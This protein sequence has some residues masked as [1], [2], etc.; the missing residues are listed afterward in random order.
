MSLLVL[1]GCPGYRQHQPNAIPSANAG[2]D[3]SVEGGAQVTLRGEGEDLDDGPGALS[4]RWEQLAGDMAALSGTSDREVT[5]LAPERSQAMV[6]S[7]RV[8]DGIEESQPDLVQVTVRFNRRPLA[9]AGGRREVANLSPLRLDGAA[10]DPDGDAIE[11]W[12]WTVESGPAGSNLASRLVGER[13]RYAV[14]TPDKKGEYSVSLV[15]GDGKAKS[16]KAHV[17][18]TSVN[19]PP[20][21]DVGAEP[22]RSIANRQ[23][24][25]VSGTASDPDGDAVASYQWDVSEIPPGGSFALANDQAKDATFTPQTKGTWVLSFHASDGDRESAPAKLLVISSNNTPQVAVPAQLSTPNGAA[26]SVAATGSDLD[27]DLLTYQWKVT[28]AAGAYNLSGAASAEATLIPQQ[29]GTYVLQVT[30]TD[31]APQSTAAVAIAQV[32]ATNRPPTAAVTSV[33]AVSAGDTVT[34]DA[35]SSSDPDGDS[36]SYELVYV[37]GPAVPGVPLQASPLL[38]FTAPAQKGMVQFQLLVTDSDGAKSGALPVQVSISNLPPV[39]E[40]GKPVLY[41]E[42]GTAV[43]LSASQS[44]DPENDPISAW[45]WAQPQGQSV[46]LSSGSTGSPSFTAPAYDPMAPP[47]LTFYLEVFDGRVWSTNQDEVEVRIT[48]DDNSYVFLSPGATGLGTRAQPMSDVVQAL[49]RASTEGKDVVFAGGTYPAASASAISLKNGVSLFGGFKPPAAGADDAW[50]RNLGAFQSVIEG[51]NGTASGLVSVL[52]AGTDIDDPTAV[53]GLTLKYNRF[54]ACGPTEAYAVHASG[55]ANLTI[56]RSRL[57]S[58]SGDCQ[59]DYAAL[60]MNGQGP[61][62]FLDNVVVTGARYRTAGV[63]VATSSDVVIRGNDITTN[64]DSAVKYRSDGIVVGPGNINVDVLANRI[65]V[66]GFQTQNGSSG[67]FVGKGQEA[68]VVPVG[69]QPW[70]LLAG[71]DSQP[72]DVLLANNQIRTRAPASIGVYVHRGNTVR[73]RHNTVSGFPRDSSKV[74]VRFADAGGCGTCSPCFPSSAVTSNFFKSV[75]RAITWGDPRTIFSNAYTD[76]ACILVHNQGSDCNA[77]TARDD[78]MVNCQLVDEASFD[79]HLKPASLCRD[80]V[81]CS[82]EVMQDMD[83]ETRPNGS[84]CDIGADEVTP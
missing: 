11:S 75:D 22:I 35:S 42:A 48:P 15:A 76:L 72:S 77:D 46:A 20:V 12:E 32:Q 49:A 23:S 63:V 60:L 3:F 61:N 73:L 27:G 31:G 39:A 7:L 14:F 78:R 8:S 79:F 70:G 2:A 24:L 82:T 68:C 13:S 84:Q 50:T 62:R 25:A 58:E 9:D 26:V 40:A 56:S 6:F 66:Q 74:A 43:M 55:A 21:A 57:I 29:K 53:D 19:N 51:W 67:I 52:A 69:S 44:S 36:L 5:F 1:G 37:A 16:G 10:T 30:V 4:F 81:A 47:E 18:V 33:P 17:F 54:T 34:L 38:S 28:S 41:A 83:G 71:N 64:V 45:R 80:T 65:T 59:Y